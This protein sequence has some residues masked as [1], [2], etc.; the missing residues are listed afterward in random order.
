MYKKVLCLLFIAAAVFSFGDTAEAKKKYLAP[1][2]RYTTRRKAER[3]WE[4]EYIR[5]E[6]R[7][8]R[9]QNR[10]N[11]EVYHSSYYVNS[12]DNG[13]SD[14]SVNDSSYVMRNPEGFS[15][16]AVAPNSYVQNKL[17]SRSPRAPK[18]AART[19]GLSSGYQSYTRTFSAPSVP[20]SAYT[21]NVNDKVSAARGEIERADIPDDKRDF[22]DRIQTGLNSGDRLEQYRAVAEWNHYRRREG[23]LK[24]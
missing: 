14:G 13:F 19:S 11:R 10:L 9:F 22:I 20:R 2:G 7:A 3:Q 18:S 17:R 1:S 6:K 16:Y 21:T 4:K 24:R 23:V 12:W 5:R 8:E 15:G